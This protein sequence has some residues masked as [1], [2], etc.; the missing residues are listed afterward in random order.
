MAL[1]INFQ[2][3]RQKLHRSF[4]NVRIVSNRMV[5][6]LSGQLVSFKGKGSPDDRIVLACYFYISFQQFL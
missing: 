5:F 2:V 4:K 3:L 6:N 1:C